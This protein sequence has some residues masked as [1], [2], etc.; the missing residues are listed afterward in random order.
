MQN[1]GIYRDLVS[2]LLAAPSVVSQKPARDVP[3]PLAQREPDDVRAFYG[4]CDGVT[5][6]SGVTVM[7]RGELHDVTQWLVLDKGLSWPSDLLVVGERR[8]AVLVL[9]LDVDGVRAGGG[10]LEVANDDLGVFERVASGLVAYLLI[11]AQAGTDPFPPAEVA[12]RK[13]AAAADAEALAQE[14]ARP[15]YPGHERL[16]SSLALTLGGWLALRGDAEGAWRAF[17]QSVALRVDSAGRGSA[18]G[19][20]RAAWRAAAHACR[21]HGLDCFASECE[22]RAGAVD[23]AAVS[24][25]R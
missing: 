5:L 7:G 4:A 14:L 20:R 2:R 10:L 6:A 18:E 15:M 12:A 21:S 9:D 16:A 24:P 25:Q 19:E 8:D 17:A 11:Q 3:W 13:A 1:D 22:A 23:P